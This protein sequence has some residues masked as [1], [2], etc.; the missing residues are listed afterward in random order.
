MKPAQTA[1][2]AARMAWDPFET[3]GSQVAKPIFSEALK[4]FGFG[5][6]G[7]GS[8]PNEIAHDDLKRARDKKQIEEMNG[9]DEQ[10][11]KENA[12]KLTAAIHKEYQD[13]A[14]SAGQEQQHLKQ[15][16]AEL[17][18]E[19]VKLASA[20]GVDTKAHLQ[21]TPQKVGVLDIKWLT[22]IVRTLRLKAEE[23][24]SG[25]DIQSQRSNAKRST[26]MLAWVSGKQ[27]KIHEQGTLQLQ[28]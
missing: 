8:K 2:N 16:M 6:K 26:G 23:S 7:L 13:Q 3:L 10:K 1:K 21:T 15:E 11:S 25:K 12:Q 28:G 20:A 17:Q 9:Q 22:S 5:P 19:V 4:E 18:S 14:T 24:K 27:M